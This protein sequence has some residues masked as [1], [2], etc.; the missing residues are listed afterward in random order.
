[1]SILETK[2]VLVFCSVG[3]NIKYQILFT[4]TKITY[5]KSNIKKILQK[6]Y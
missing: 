4:F 2:G 6:S 1:M 5:A 3:E